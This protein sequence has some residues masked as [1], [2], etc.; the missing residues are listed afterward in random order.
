[1][2]FPIIDY[3]EDLSARWF[4]AACAPPQARL[5]HL[6]AKYTDPGELP[7]PADTWS[8]CGRYLPVG[9][10]VRPPKHLEPLDLGYCL[11]CA[12]SLRASLGIHISMARG[13]ARLRR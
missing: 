4:L 8:A 6:V 5:R 7:L 9:R 12:A 3:P 1:M 2:D 10:E 11:R 13:G